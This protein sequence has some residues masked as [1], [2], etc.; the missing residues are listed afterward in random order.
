M[1]MADI[2]FKLDS[3]KV[4]NFIQFPSLLDVLAKLGGL[5]SLLRIVFTILMEPIQKMMLKIHLYDKLHR[6]EIELKDSKEINQNV[7]PRTKTRLW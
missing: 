5:F 3:L 4:Q 1:T 2:N 6:E 7:V